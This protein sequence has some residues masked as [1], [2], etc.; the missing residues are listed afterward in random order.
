MEAY[1]HLEPYLR[2][3]EEL[4]AKNLSAEDVRVYG[5]LV[6]FLRRG[7]KRIRPVLTLLSCGACGGAYES[8][9]EPAAIIE[10]F[11]NFTLIHDDIED[12]SQFRRG[13]PALHIAHGMPMAMNSGDALYTFLWRELLALKLKPS[14][15]VALQKLYA[16]SFKRV[17]DGQG[18]ELSWIRG[19]RFDVSEKD[20]FDM[21]GGKTAALMGLSCEVGAFVAG[22]GKRGRK[23]LRAYG[24]AI[25]AAFQIQDDVL[26]V[27]GDFEKYQKEIGGDISEGKRTLMVV[28]CLA[29]APE[30]ER[31]RLTEILASHSKKAEDIREA[32]ALLK[33]NGSVEYAQKCAD[34]IVKKA[35]RTIARLPEGKDKAALLGMADYVIKRER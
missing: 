19:E 17:V 2:S 12:D 34:G 20:Y 24:E 9:V 16:D 5:L 15:L 27:T 31:K 23:A 6:P 22:S 35:V 25:G 28:H 4:M 29:A 3:V 13:E 32:I 21:I 18:V 10:M 7:G 11:H 8:A 26:N 30:A 33:K 1:S 14:R